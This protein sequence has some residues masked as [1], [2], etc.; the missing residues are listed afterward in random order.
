MAAVLT[1]RI[2]WTFLKQIVDLL[3]LLLSLLG[4]PPLLHLVLLRVK[5][6]LSK[7]EVALGK[8]SLHLLLHLVLQ[9]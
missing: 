3:F 6:V 5:V 8:S 1:I 2:T 9:L 7:Y 4:R